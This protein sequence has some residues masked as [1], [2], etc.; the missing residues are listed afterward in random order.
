MMLHLKYKLPI[1]ICF[2]VLCRSFKEPQPPSCFMIC[3]FAGMA[4]QENWFCD[5]RTPASPESGKL[6][7]CH[8]PAILN[9]DNYLMHRCLSMSQAFLQQYVHLDAMVN[10]FC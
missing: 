6:P 2:V 8:Q 9:R 4:F 5:R 7:R 3:S 10:R 1:T